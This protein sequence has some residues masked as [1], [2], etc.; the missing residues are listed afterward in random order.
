MEAKEFR[1]I[2]YEKDD[3]TGIVTVTINRPEIKNALTITV[4]L[5]LNWAADAVQNDE[6]AKAMILTGAKPVD[7]D[8]PANEAFSS[9][10]YFDLSEYE[11]LDEATK[12][13]IDLTD[14]AQKK[15][16]LKLWQLYKPLI[17]AING[18][19]IGGGITIPLACAD[20]IY[21]S[22][23]A[24]ARFP[25]INLGIIP[26]LASS[27]LLPRML[28]FQRAKEI[29]FF[30]EDLSAQ[31]LYE[32]GLV[33]K[34]L[35]HDELLPYTTQMAAKLIP[36]QGA[37]LAVSL[38]KQA[39]HKPLIEAVTKALDN[40]NEALNKTFSTTDFFEAIAARKEKRE[41]VF[42]GK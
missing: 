14:I 26:E 7:S 15:L 20:L 42:K 2:L 19:A 12:K 25:F 29:C 18:L 40:E 27:F 30:G 23:H 11:A 38:T 6:S 5:E 39:M 22:E 16:C 13:E 37:G 4:L 28:G 10:G 3:G 35:P 36:P 31:K 8:D 34:V 41:P 17:A 21:V 1:N 33:N 24:W 9:G 32:L